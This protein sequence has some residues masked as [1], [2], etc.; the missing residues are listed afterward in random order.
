MFWAEVVTNRLHGVLLAPNAVYEGRWLVS[1]L[2]VPVVR[3]TIATETVPKVLGAR[4]QHPAIACRVAARACL[5]TKSG[6]PEEITVRGAGHAAV[7]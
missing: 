4:G 1:G 2:T 3:A 7:G 5:K 6:M